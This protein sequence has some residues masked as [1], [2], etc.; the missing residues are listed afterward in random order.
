M[1]T[2]YWMIIMLAMMMLSS[3]SQ[4]IDFF[5]QPDTSS[6]NIGD[7]IRLSGRIGPSDTLR[8]FTIYLSNDTTV[9]DLASPPVAGSLIANRQGLDFRYLDHVA[10]E[11]DWLEIGATV[12]STDYWAGPGE[13]FQVSFVLRQCGDISLSASV[14]FRRPNATYIAG[15]YDPPE[16]F[17][18]RA[19][20]QY[21]T[22]LT[23][24]P[25]PPEGIVLRWCSVTLDTLGHELLA[26]PNYRV[27]RQQILPV[28]N[29]AAPVATVPDTFF[30]DP[31]DT[32]TDY[33][34]Y[35]TAQAAP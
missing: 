10:S 17:I 8:G 9:L 20:P 7:T 31:F 29:P 26:P 27:W 33:I 14:G 28:V 32:G 21:P 4:A 5:F 15:N 35:V 30:T 13:L 23:L 24:S 18:C 19:V 2:V 34:Y 3:E 11:P 12:F 6:G 25:A 16:I 22:C 1:R